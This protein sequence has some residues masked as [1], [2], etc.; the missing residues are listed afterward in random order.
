MESIRALATYMYTYMT[1]DCRDMMSSK[2][3][4]MHAPTFVCVYSADI[5]IV[6]SPRFNYENVFTFKVV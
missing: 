2:T 3:R 4:V 5:M 6:W 1:S